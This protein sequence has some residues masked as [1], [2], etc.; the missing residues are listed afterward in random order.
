M[1]HAEIQAVEKSLPKIADHGAALFFLAKRYAQIGDLDKGLALLKECI[2][3][4][5]GFDPSEGPS[6]KLCAPTP[7]FRL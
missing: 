5:Q 7:S 3:L 1:R 4:D 6:L 2:A